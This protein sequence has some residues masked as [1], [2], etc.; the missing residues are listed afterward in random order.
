MI[1]SNHYENLNEGIL[2]S[3][4]PSKMY[5]IT[6]VSE[7]DNHLIYLRR[8]KG[9]IKCKTKEQLWISECKR[10]AQETHAL[11][12]CDHTLMQPL[13]QKSLRDNTEDPGQSCEAWSLPSNASY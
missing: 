9:L 12:S 5:A 4:K 3:I 11:E 1:L 7:L 10:K 6:S 2:F 8:C 13:T